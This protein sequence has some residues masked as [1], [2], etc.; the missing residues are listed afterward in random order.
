MADT[1]QIDVNTDSGDLPDGRAV[2]HNGSSGDPEMEGLTL[3]EKKSLLVNR[4]LD[5][6]GM[7]KYQW[8][9]FFLCGFGYL[10]DLLTAQAF[11]LVEPSIQQEFG[12]GDAQSGNIFSSFSAGLT[13]GAFVWGVLVDIIGRQYAFNFTVLISSIFALCLAAPN[14][15]NGILVLTAFVGFGVGGNI[16]IDTTICLEFLPQNR[17]FLLA[18]LSVFQPIGVVVTCALAYAFIPNHS[19]GNG[20]DGKPLKACSVVAEGA[21]CCTKSSNMGWRYTLL[22][23]GAICLGIFFVRF[24]LFNF[25]ESPKYLLYRGKDEKAVKVLHSIA[26][27]NGRESSISLKDF[28]ALTNEATSMSSNDTGTPML[29]AGAAQLKATWGQKLRIEM[30]RYKLLFATSTMARLTILVW[31]TYGFDYWGFSIAGK[32]AL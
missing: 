1:K 7:G 2:Y 30:E 32:P 24:V 14:T 4:E 25:Q 27:F 3:F 28:E 13:A 5:A 12:F 9:I 18:M 19:C 10:V 26:K 6:H 16:P 15:Y 31:I 17:R 21:A 20:A 11:G 23:L 8:Y 22:C 29:G